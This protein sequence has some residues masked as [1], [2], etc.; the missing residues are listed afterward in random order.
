MFF[1][2]TTQ[3]GYGKIK[4]IL[5]LFLYDMAFKTLYI[6]LVLM[7]SIEQATNYFPYPYTPA[8]AAAAVAPL[9][10]FDSYTIATGNQL[11][12]A[13][14][15]RHHHHSHHHQ[16][17][18]RQQQQQQSQFMF[19]GLVQTTQTSYHAYSSSSS[20]GGGGG[21]NSSRSEAFY[22]NMVRSKKSGHVSKNR[23]MGKRGSTDQIN[24]QKSCPNCSRYWRNCKCSN[25]KNRP[26]PKPYCKFVPPRMLK[27][28][29]S[30]ENDHE[31]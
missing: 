2:G 16:Q 6:P 15:S 19:H 26:A 14:P 13:S 4:K 30:S 20:S 23:A 27:K 10:N 8:A 22:P 25:I 12:K 1:I 11:T 3:N 5:F 17:H 18:Q 7:P 9:S 24:L 28:Q 21:K 31:N 29:M